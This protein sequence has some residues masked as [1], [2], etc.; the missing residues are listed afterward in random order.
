MQVLQLPVQ[1]G[2][3]LQSPVVM[4]TPF[5]TQPTLPIS[6]ALTPAACDWSGS[7][8]SKMVWGG[9]PAREA[10]YHSLSDAVIEA[11]NPSAPVP[12]MKLM[13]GGSVAGGAFFRDISGMRKST[14]NDSIHS[15]GSYSRM[16]EKFTDMSLRLRGRAELWEL[17][18]E[19]LVLSKQIGEGAGGAVFLARWRGLECA[20]KVLAAQPSETA[21][22]DMINEISTISHLRHPNLVLF[23]GACTVQ[24]PLLILSEYMAGGSLEE[25]FELK[26]KK[27]DKNLRPLRNQAYRW[28]LDLTRAVAFLHQCS[29]PI[30]HRDLKP[31]NLL[32]TADLKLKVSDFGLCKTLKKARQDHVSY[33]MTGNTG[34]RRYMAPEVVLSDPNYNEK[35]DI[36]SMAM[37]FWYIFK[38]QRP[39]DST[40]PRLIATLASTRGLRP[41]AQAIGWVPLEGLVEQMW[42]HDRELRP[43][44]PECVPSHLRLYF[45]FLAWRWSRFALVGV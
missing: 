4:F 6:P 40:D 33:Q 22:A 32:L 13:D 36:Y 27:G 39:F 42:S 28:V 19:Q 24:E 23:L 1:P 29:S 15:E 25:Y 31:A 5:H 7:G 9:I 41:D 10:S 8:H 12:E 18:R 34:T 43:S 17:P 16:V 2:Q 3:V 26:L 21:H 44:S 35:V 30:I 45:W 20:A 14:S 38:G 11:S 37:N